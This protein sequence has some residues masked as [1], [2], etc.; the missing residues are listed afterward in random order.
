MSHLIYKSHF[1]KLSIAV[2]QSGP[3][4]NKCDFKFVAVKISMS[5]LGV[6]FM[7]D[8]L[9]SE[10]FALALSYTNSKVQD[11]LLLSTYL[12]QNQ[13]QLTQQLVQMVGSLRSSS[14]PEMDN[15]IRFIIH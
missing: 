2:S 5:H 10:V 6:I 15:Y 9:S 12:T 4:F 13:P 8:S 14:G 3:I 1:H 7:K 11:I